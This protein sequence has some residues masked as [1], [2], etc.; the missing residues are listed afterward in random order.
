[1]NLKKISKQISD[2]TTFIGKVQINVSDIQISKIEATS[3]KKTI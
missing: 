1:M 2:E 3:K